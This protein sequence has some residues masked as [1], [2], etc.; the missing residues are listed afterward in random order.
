MINLGAASIFSAGAVGLPGDRRFYLQIETATGQRWYL[1]EKSQVGALAAAGEE[2]LERNDL[3][4]AGA[5]TAAGF[6][7]PGDVEWRIGQIAIEFD[8]DTSM[9]EIVVVPTEDE[10]EAIRF[11]VTPQQMGAMAAEAGRAI[12][13]GRPECPRCGLAMDAE[14]HTCPTTNGDLRGHRP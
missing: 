10:D 13:A 1:C 4:G 8:D 12:S 9:I 5:D 3:A 14:G 11:E 6:A 2:I 7:P